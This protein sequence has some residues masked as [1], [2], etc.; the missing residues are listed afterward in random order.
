MIFQVLLPPACL[1]T[2][3]TLLTRLTLLTYAT[4]STYLLAFNTLRLA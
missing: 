2:L 3:L 4:Y 1:L